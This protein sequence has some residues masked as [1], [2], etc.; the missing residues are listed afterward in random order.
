MGVKASYAKWKAMPGVPFSGVN[1]RQPA[2]IFL[3]LYGALARNETTALIASAVV[4]VCDERAD[5]EAKRVDPQARC[6][7]DQ[8]EPC[9]P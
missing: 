7:P 8:D 4:L 1:C 5:I 9:D 3:P 6:D 2:R